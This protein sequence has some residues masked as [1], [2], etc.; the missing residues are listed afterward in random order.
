M[1]AVFLAVETENF[2]EKTRSRQL[3]ARRHY[4]VVQ[5]DRHGTGLADDTVSSSSL[6]ELCPLL[7]II[8][9]GVRDG[10]RVARLC[11]RPAE[12]IPVCEPMGGL[13]P[14]RHPISPAPNDP[15]ERLAGCHQ[16]RPAVGCD[17]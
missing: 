10:P 5:D 13:V 16:V 3:V 17:D 11:L 14:V 12:Y 6:P 7:T 8:P 4:G 15:I 2:R 1:I 9:P